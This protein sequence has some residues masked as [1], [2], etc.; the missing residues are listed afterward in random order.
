MRLINTNIRETLEVKEFW[1]SEI[2]RYA[3]LSHTW[4]EEEVSFQQ[5]TQ[6]PREE[7]SKMKGFA[8]IEKTC[9]LARTSGIEWAWVDTCCI[10][11]SS[12]AELTE[13]INSMFHWYQESAVCYAYL[14]D[15]KSEKREE[16]RDDREKREDGSRERRGQREDGEKPEKRGEKP[17]AEKPEQNLSLA[18]GD[19]KSDDGKALFKRER[20]AD[21]RPV[22]EGLSFS[23]RVDKYAH[24]RW[25]TRGWTLQ[26]LI[27][28]RRLGFYDCNWR[29]QGEK[30]ALS[31]ELAEI[32]HI[33][34]RILDKANLL[35]TVSVAQRMSWASNRQTTR[36]EDMAYCLLG[37]FGV[38]IPMLYGEG[39]KA[40]IRLQE[41]IIKESNDLSLFAW[42]AHATSQ[43]H[44]GVLALSPNDF[45]D[46]ADIELWDEAMYND[47]FVVTSKGLRVTPV[48]GGGLRLGRDATYVL[49][50]QCHR[51]GSDKDLGIFLRQHGCDMYTRVW[52]DD[53]SET[54]GYHP[55]VAETKGRMFYISKMVSPVLS[56]VLGSSHRSSI[57]LSRAI[58]A[59]KNA[60]FLIKKDGS[61]EPA[62]H[63]DT[64]RDL[65]LTQGMRDFVCR[66]SFSQG[67]DR[68]GSPLTMECTLRDGKVSV[69]FTIETGPGRFA[70]GRV[71]QKRDSRGNVVD[72][73]RASVFQEAVSGQPM[74]F[75]TVDVLS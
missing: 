46:C 75:V 12:S 38:Q 51:R 57:N 25:F 60:E 65:F 17:H 39:S 28:P 8:K 21:R 19:K 53:F 73:L 4:E 71:L 72:W 61:V 23:Q 63:W 11:K 14:S 9:Q 68:R 3:I 64:Q 48:A 24:C 1:G 45:T 42:R 55:E 36:A 66:L 29:F 5:F 67:S 56:V 34:K 49:N 6:L 44:W 15:L 33:N 43:K 50:L 35:S 10:D 20:S 54:L 47:E 69:N 59:L 27:A 16:K 32:T 58:A 41:E 13:A 74:Y 40:F 31:G 26:E 30:D 7:L 52:P 62:G 18:V 37:I 22:N 70:S 2:P